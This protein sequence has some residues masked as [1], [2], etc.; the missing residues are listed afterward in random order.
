MELLKLARRDAA[1]W[2]EENPQ[3]SG[4]RD[5][6]LKKRLLKAYG[7]TLGLGDVG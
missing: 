6:L 2:I 7:K 5:A 3:L 1:R 4:E